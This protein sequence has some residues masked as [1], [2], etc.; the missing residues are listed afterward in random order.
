MIEAAPAAVIGEVVITWDSLWR[1]C[2]EVRYFFCGKYISFGANKF[3]L[4]QI[5]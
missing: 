1:V 3:L 2:M 4:D 5:H